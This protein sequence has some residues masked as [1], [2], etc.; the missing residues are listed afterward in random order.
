MMHSKIQTFIQLFRLQ[1]AKSTLLSQCT[2][3]GICFILVSLTTA[4]LESVFYFDQ[5]T[6]W[7]IFQFLLIFFGSGAAYIILRYIFHIRQFFGNSSDH[8]LADQFKFRHPEIGDRVLNSLQLEKNLPNFTE[9]S[10][11]ANHAIEKTGAQLDAVPLHSLRNP[12]SKPLKQ[13]LYSALGITLLLA[14]LNFDSLPH[15]YYR[16]MNPIKEFPVPMPFVLN[17]LTGN[18]SVLGG[19]T[20][21]VSIAGYGDLPDSLQLHWEDR[22]SSGK[23]TLSN[24]REIFHYTFTNIK[25]DTRYWAA[26]SS[27]SFFSA[28]SEIS[29]EQDTIFVTDR[30]IIQEIQFTIFPPEY[31]QK[32]AYEHPGNIT[33]VTIPQGSRIHF[34]GLT[35][36]S[37]Q[38]AWLRL[39]DSVHQVQAEGK[40]IRGNFFISSPVI[41]SIFVEDDNG[42]QNLQPP[43]YRFSIMDDHPPEI[44]VRMP[45]KEFE[46]DESDLIAFDIQ[47]SDDYGFSEAWLEYR[48]KAPDYLPQDT[49]LYK[50]SISELQRQVKSQQLYHEWS[51]SQFSLAPE[52]EIHIQ[53]VVA[54]NNTLSG[55]SLTHSSIL[56]GR[57]PSLEDLFHRLEE[58]EEDVEEY[59]EEIQMNLEEVREMVEE[60][61]LELLKSEEVS[62][63]QEQTA[64]EVLE[65]VDEVFDQIEQIQETMQ[66]IQEQAEKNN[67][68]SEELVNKFSQFQELLDEIMTPEMLEAL[69]KLQEAMDEMDPQKM[70]DAL[71]DFDYDLSEFEE[72][73]DRFIEMFELALAEQ[74]MD[75]VVKRLEKLLEEQTGIVEEL[76][77]DENADLS[78]LASRERR[79]E[80]SFKSL[81]DVMKDA[82]EAMEKLSPEASQQL[83]E[84]AESDLAENTKSDLKDAR[85][86]MQNENQSGASS[87]AGQ[88]A[89]GLES[90]LQMAQDIQSQFQEDTVDEMLRKFLALIRNLLYISQEQENLIH[91]TESLRSRSPKVIE[92]AVR[93]DKILRENQ[94]LMT[95]LAELS[96][97]TF[98]ITPEIASAIG[99]TQNAMDRTIAK[100]EQKQTSSARREMKSILEGLNQTAHLLLESADQMQQSGS[101]SGMAEFMEQMEQMSQ[102]QQ[103]INQGTMQLPQ[104]GM[105][106]QQQMMEQLQKQQEQLKQQLEELLGE[107]PGQESGGAGKAKEEMEEVIED[108]RRKQVDRRTQE[109]QER[110]LSRMLD[111]H[112]SLTQKDYSEKRKSNTGEEIIYSGPTGLPADL[113]EREMLLI[114]AMESALQE[115]HSREYQNMMKKYFRT[116]QKQE[117]APH[118]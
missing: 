66:K 86:E 3:L 21:S 84:L 108:F 47:T 52:D 39:D 109:R 10:D 96:R 36:K 45:D 51:L 80:E 70:L 92:T 32:D 103:G 29:T 68:V 72:Q 78:T 50:R 76:A 85:Q 16:M 28:W 116:L 71:E 18:Q 37:V 118:E 107:H 114:N 27:P 110:I 82:A 113:G 22:E 93:Q 33:D 64:T 61:E 56:K 9:G 15:A 88:A 101:G 8:Y 97:Q 20:L 65:K 30:P 112:K 117:E 43:N 73:L 74:K 87:S 111:S 42:V 54:D 104:L 7:R 46:L 38:T 115:G 2:L 105:A 23:I 31:M 77:E 1:T 53:V 41:A 62:W 19:D 35:S 99:R 5:S 57:Y 17:S 49:N 6:R 12:L 25:R 83:S 4:I 90:M 100:L 13:W 91:D 44:I 55:P 75:E 81:E 94:Q 102:Q 98:H 95:Q 58:E 34:S 106:A 40:R 89:G 79:Q 14:A 11:L 63:E 48:I 26:F 60:L 59:G 24:E 67:L 69:E